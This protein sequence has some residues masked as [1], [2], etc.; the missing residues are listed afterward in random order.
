MPVSLTDGD[1]LALAVAGVVAAAAVLWLLMSSVCCLL[2]VATR[3]P[4]WARIAPRLMR[5]WVELVLAASVA[6]L[7]GAPAHA[8]VRDVPVVRAPAPAP[9]PPPVRAVD[10]PPPET[11]RPSHVVVHG[12]NLWLI[13]AQQLRAARGRA[14]TAAEIVPYWRAV[15]ATNRA[16]LRSRDPNLIYPGEIVMLPPVL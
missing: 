12:D 3:R 5:R 9:T 4:A 14:P 11:P 16:H 15:I 2:A 13:A 6:A 1:A 7:P 8:A 10:A